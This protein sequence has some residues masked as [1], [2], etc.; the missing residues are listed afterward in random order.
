M[1]RFRPT[2]HAPARDQGFRVTVTVVERRLFKDHS[3]CLGSVIQDGL[4]CHLCCH[5][6]VRCRLGNQESQ[7]KIEAWRGCMRGSG[8]QLG[9]C[10]VHRFENVWFAHRALRPVSPASLLNPLSRSP[11]L[12]RACLVAS[13]MCVFIVWDR[14]IPGLLKGTSTHVDDLRVS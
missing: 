4:S 13:G 1:S 8:R 7:T 6:G 12:S 3:K 11:R 5:C 9:W 14:E 10:G 2:L